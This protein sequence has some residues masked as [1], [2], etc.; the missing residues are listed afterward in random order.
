[1]PKDVIR[2]FVTPQG[3][4]E[5]VAKDFLARTQ[6]Y[7]KETGTCVVA[8]SGGRA[9]NGFL[10][11]LRSPA[12]LDRIDW[13][14]IYFLWTDERFV[15]QSSE[16]NNFHRAKE[17]LFSHISGC[18]HF[19]P[20]QTEAGT[21]EE[22]ATLYDKELTTVLSACEKEAADILILGLGDDGHIA[23]L[24][25]KSPVLEEKELSVR[26]VPSGKVWDRVTMTFP[27]LA[28]TKDVWFAVVGETKMAALAR[29]LR[30]RET[31]QDDT[32]QDRIGHVLPG[33]VLS[34]D[35]VRWYVDEAAGGKLKL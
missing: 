30:Q 4:T 25:A 7:I 2:Q 3:V 14:N 5:A 29:V 19:Y 27:F 33:A 22:V 6:A 21:L 20:V 12:Y 1:M 26:A 9:V 24:F 17:R 35:E 31:Y 8:I 16:D 23:S 34:Q 11:L 13:E 15:P 28:K 32:W 18:C 10:E